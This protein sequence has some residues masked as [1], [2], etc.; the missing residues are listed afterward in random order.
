VG[1][2]TG[3]GL[4]LLGVPSALLLGVIA[5]L[6]NLIPYIGI[7]ISIVPALIVALT[8][9]SPVGGLLRVGG[10]FAAVQFIDGSVT[11]PRIVGGSV[12][13]HPVMTMLALAFGGAVLGFAGLLLAIPL[14]VLIR[15]IGAR[16]LMRYRLSAMYG[17]AGAGRGTGM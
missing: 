12:G 6:A 16:L 17:E 11:G 3:G 7:V 2:L 10:V 4:A 1:I 8:M 9:P 14:A 5:G 15:M 13:L